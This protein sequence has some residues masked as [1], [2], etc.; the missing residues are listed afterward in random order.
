[1]AHR[2]GGRI[3]TGAPSPAGTPPST[4][5][6]D[7]FFRERGIASVELAPGVA[8][9]L[10]FGDRRTGH[11]ATRRA[12]GLF[13]F[14][15]MACFDIGG[16]DAAAF[17]ER[18]QTR[19]VGGMQPGAILYTLLCRD[20]GTVVNDATLWCR[21]GGRFT[22]FT[23]RRSDAAHLRRRAEGLDITLDDRSSR[24]ATCAVQGP[25][26]LRTLEAAFPG[27]PWATLGYFRFRTFDFGGGRCDIG[28]LGYSGEAGFE[29]IVD[30]G[31]ARELWQRLA[32][33]GAP[34]G[35]A[36]C[37]FEAVDSLRIEAGCLLFTRELAAPATPYE[38]RL[39]RLV[40]TDGASFVG[41][42]ALNAMR[43][44]EPERWLAGFDIDDRGGRLARAPLPSIDAAAPPRAGEALL[45]SVA[46]SPL[47]ERSIGLGF[48]APEDRYP[49]TSVRLQTG[50]TA[51]VARLPFYDPPKTRPRR[52]WAP[53]AAN[54][55]MRA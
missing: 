31:C 10:R 51:R 13:D 44:A 25:L 27:H 29:A 12:V 14:S 4:P 38:L 35:L 20:D 40:R 43:R 32:A 19:A 46:L 52:D 18:I 36:E 30:D 28:R 41:A 3:L 21:G 45:T 53:A 48:V 2:A 34:Y 9:P 55:R 50:H 17:I 26:P 15:F 7:Y 11:M 33:A 6:H 1:M 39:G 47:L 16:D 24:R 5:L 54:G 22:L 37:G 8:T 42:R 23:G 49:G